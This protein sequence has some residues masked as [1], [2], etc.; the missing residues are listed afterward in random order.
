MAFEL[1][2]EQEVAAR[3]ARKRTVILHNRSDYEYRNMIDG[4]E[5]VIPANGSITVRRRDAIRIRGTYYKPKGPRNE[6]LPCRLEI[7]DKGVPGAVDSL[8]V[9]NLCGFEAKNQTDLVAHSVK[10]HAEKLPAELRKAQPAAER[11]RVKIYPC[12]RC[13]AE[14]ESLEAMREHLKGCKK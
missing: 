7:E 13:D 10:E 11:I 8:H 4:D 6:S 9:C 2:E 12:I 14:F 1:A 5:V 3:K